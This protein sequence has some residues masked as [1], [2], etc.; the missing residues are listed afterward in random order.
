M[1]QIT[2][3]PV[4]AAKKEISRKKISSKEPTL[5]VISSSAEKKIKAGTRKASARVHNQL[6]R[7]G[8]N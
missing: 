1:K 7:Q 8:F 6:C 4:R 3:K 2:K 5:S